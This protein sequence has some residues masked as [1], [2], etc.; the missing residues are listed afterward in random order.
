MKNSLKNISKEERVFNYRL[1]RGRRVVESRFGILATRFR[2][3]LISIYLPPETVKTIVLAAC[4]LHK[5][6]GT[7]RKNPITFWYLL[8][9]ITLEPK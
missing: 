1:S 9:L 5:M 6:L 7:R 2:M 4:T 8:V 3:L